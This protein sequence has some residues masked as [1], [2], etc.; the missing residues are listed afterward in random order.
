MTQQLHRGI[1][2]RGWN[3]YVHIKASTRI[4]TALL[5]VTVPRW[6]QPRCPATGKWRTKCGLSTQWSIIHPQQRMESWTCCKMN[7]LWKHPVTW[8]QPVLR[9]SHITRLHLNRQSP[10]TLASGSAVAQGEK[11]K[12]GGLSVNGAQ[13][14]SWEDEKCAKARSWCQ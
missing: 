3:T 10:G 11:R 7:E 4:L 9:G 1:Y 12:E 5:F 2:L 8:K 13:A 14:S 6:K